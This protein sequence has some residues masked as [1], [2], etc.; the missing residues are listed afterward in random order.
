MLTSAPFKGVCPLF[1]RLNA[2]Y[3]GF[4]IG[5]LASPA[6]DSAEVADVREDLVVLENV[7]YRRGRKRI[8]D[9]LSLSVPVGKTEAIMGPSETGKTT[10]LRLIGGQ[11]QPDRGAGSRSD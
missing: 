10:L 7:V 3:S 11:I 4:L 6:F 9:N 5:M 1:A 8:F 2:G